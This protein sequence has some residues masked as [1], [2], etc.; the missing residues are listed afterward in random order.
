M[1]CRAWTLS[2]WAFFSMVRPGGQPFPM[3]RAA[4]QPCGAAATAAP[5]GGGAG[6]STVRRPEG[7]QATPD[8]CVTRAAGG[9]VARRAPARVRCIPLTGPR[10]LF[11]PIGGVG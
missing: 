6:R 10:H 4:S 5:P 2:W 8:P 11:M 1:M 7:R 3:V 9:S